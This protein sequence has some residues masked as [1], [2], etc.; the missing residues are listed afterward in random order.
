MN[1]SRGG[2]RSGGGRKPKSDNVVIGFPGGEVAPSSAD[3]T[4]L[5]EPPADLP[6][7]QQVVWRAYAPL[8]IAQLTLV[9]ATV[10][11]FRELCRRVA[12]ADEQAARLAKFGSETA[13]K[14]YERLSALVG[15]SLKDFKLTAFGKAA[16]GAAQRNN[17]GSNPWAAIG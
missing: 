2:E 12:F 9:E 7:A 13:A 3:A 15:A 4:A 17:A 14:R 6:P 5:L 16:E 8:A 10:P 11:G 1:M